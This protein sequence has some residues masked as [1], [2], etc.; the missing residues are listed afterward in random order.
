MFQCFG[1]VHTNYVF[2]LLFP[3][4]FQGMGHG[5]RPW[6]PRSRASFQDLD[7][8]SIER[9]SYQSAGGAKSVA[10]QCRL[11]WQVSWAG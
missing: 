2:L 10:G 1:D 11:R 3:D 8:S 4:P 5:G 7:K 6:S 9:K